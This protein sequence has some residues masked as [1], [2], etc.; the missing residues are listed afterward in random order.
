MTNLQYKDA[1]LKAL[2][3]LDNSTNSVDEVRKILSGCD[4]DF[5]YGECEGVFNALSDNT[6][7]QWSEC[8]PDNAIKFANDGIP[9]VGICK[10]KVMVIIP[11]GE[12]TAESGIV[13]AA[14]S[15]TADE[16]ENYKF[17]SNTN[18]R[19]VNGWTSDVPN[20]LV[21][22]FG[23]WYYRACWAKGV[24]GRVPRF[25]QMDWGPCLT[26]AIMSGSYNLD[27]STENVNT[28]FN[29]RY[30]NGYENTNGA[31]WESFADAIVFNR[32][33][34]KE[35]LDA[36][37]PVVVSGKNNSGTR[38][39]ALVASYTGNG[40]RNSDF[41]VIDPWHDAPFPTTYDEFVTRFPNDATISYYSTGKKV[42]RPMLIFK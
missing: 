12:D 3:S 14:N 13:R 35:Q 9:T 34:M 42:D 37:R 5:P 20:P 18:V 10:E 19:A 25:V 40:T 38:H 11:D 36:E 28:F 26:Y 33:T 6:F 1:V 41:T 31:L 39:F 17:F 22:G 27:H 2:E 16:R 7:A 30:T 21:E 23:G 29:N 8:S 15:L 24:A 4:V 32:A